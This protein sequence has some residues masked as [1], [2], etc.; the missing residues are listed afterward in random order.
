MASG[1]SLSRRDAE[2]RADV[3][4]L[5]QDR[6]HRVLTL[7][8]KG[9]RIARVPLEPATWTALET[10]LHERVASA[11]HTDWRGP[12]GPLLAT[13]T[14]GRLRQGFC[15]DWRSVAHGGRGRVRHFRPCPVARV[16]LRFSY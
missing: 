8:H 15:G 5:G 13:A 4:D 6:K 7:V 1:S 10:Y 16:R 2:S 14:G 3:A 11:R 12:R 9:S